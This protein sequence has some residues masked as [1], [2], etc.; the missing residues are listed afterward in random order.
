[1]SLKRSYHGIQR[2]MHRLVE[3]KWSVQFDIVIAIAEAS[4]A[5]L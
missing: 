1:M 5:S 2:I 3:I 4:C